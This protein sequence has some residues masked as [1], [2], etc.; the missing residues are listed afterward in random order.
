MLSMG[1]KLSDW[2]TLI[3]ISRDCQMGEA[4]DLKYLAVTLTG[5]IQTKRH[6]TF[7]SKDSMGVSRVCQNFWVPLLSQEEVK[8]QTAGTSKNFQVIDM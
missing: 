1:T 8:L 5:S 3:G 6:V 2:I 4:M 7:R